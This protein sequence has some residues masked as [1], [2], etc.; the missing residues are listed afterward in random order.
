MNKRWKMG[1]RERM[2]CILAP[3]PRRVHLAPDKDCHNAPSKQTL[4][5]RRG[6]RESGGWLDG[7][8]RLGKGSR[9]CENSHN[10]VNFLKMVIKRCVLMEI[11]RK[12]NTV[13]NLHLFLS[14]NPINCIC[15]SFITFYILRASIC[16]NARCNFSSTSE[17]SA[18]KLERWVSVVLS[19]ERFAE[20]IIRHHKIAQ[21]SWRY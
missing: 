2:L 6:E 3:P 16:L 13:L 18:L 10:A 4:P 15:Q 14:Q 11:H 21:M 8:H 20:N 7:W 17:S 5:R 9:Q 19:L 1:G 12:R